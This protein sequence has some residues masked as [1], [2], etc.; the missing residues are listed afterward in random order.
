[1]HMKYLFICVH[2]DDLEFN[3]SNLINY[4]TSTDN[5]V[6]ILSLTQGEFGIFLDQ[7][8]GPR[9]A[10][11]RKKELINAAAVNGV[12]AENIHFGDIID[13]FVKYNSEAL[14]Y[15]LKWLNKLQPDI[16][17]APEPYYTYYWHSDHINCGRLAYYIFKNKQDFLK[18]PLKA[19]YFY[20][21]FKPTIWWPF[22]HTSHALNSLSFHRS[23]WWL[24]KRAFLY[25]PIEKFNFPNR[26]R[27]GNWKFAERYRRVYRKGKN[28]A[29]NFIWKVILGKISRSQLTNFPRSHYTVLDT[30]TPFGQKIAQLRSEK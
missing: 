3:C 21:S 18:N 17:F 5:S 30:S 2:P 6:E 26:R 27:I 28:P 9:L 8:K 20:T 1:M 16:I 23:Q 10:K 24:L 19:L 7:W 29:I 11:I 4:L 12:S 15:L 13:G 25:Y 22:Q 14:G